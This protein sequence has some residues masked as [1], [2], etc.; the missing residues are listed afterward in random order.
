[1]VKTNNLVGRSVEAT[2][3]KEIDVYAMMNKARD[4]DSRPNF[5]PPINADSN[6]NLVSLKKK[7][8]TPKIF[9]L[10]E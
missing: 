4:I 7:K 6:E 8:V 3:G 10:S 9:D 5:L 2:K 1:M